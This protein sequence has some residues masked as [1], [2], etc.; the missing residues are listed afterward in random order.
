MVRP[1]VP[2]IFQ[3]SVSNAA[4]AKENWFEGADILRF[5][6]PSAIGL[7]QFKYQSRNCGP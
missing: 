4:L 2:Q 5:G 6:Y 7:L 3:R 1:Q